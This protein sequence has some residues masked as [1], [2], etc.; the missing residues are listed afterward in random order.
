[1]KF[2]NMSDKTTLGTRM[3]ENY[4]NRTKQFLVRRCP[5]IIRLDGKAFHTY[6]KGLERPFDEGLIQDM[7]LTTAYLCENIQGAKCG[8]TQSDE[9]TILL[10]DYDKLTSHAW[11]DYNVQKITSVAASMAT[12]KFNQL[13]LLRGCSSIAPMGSEYDV[14]GISRYNLEDVNLAFFDA[15]VFQIP[16]KEEVVNCFVWR[17]QDA[18][19]NSVSMLAQSL[20][21][22]KEL[23]KKHAGD[24]QEMCF[25]KG[26][27]WNDLSPQKKRGSFIIKRMYVNGIGLHEK[28]EEGDNLLGYFSDTNK[29]ASFNKDLKEW[30]DIEDQTIRTK[31]EVVEDTPFFSRDRNSVLKFI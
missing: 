4:E 24:M 16:D 10:T 15:R 5:T 7:Q 25:Q 29:Y 23:H 13:R 27:N 2:I 28:D 14:E 30:I 3:K 20:Y 9:I 11:F 19:K 31:W 22:H 18:E 1:M 8:Y 26:H 21:S 12:A 17:Q 6:T